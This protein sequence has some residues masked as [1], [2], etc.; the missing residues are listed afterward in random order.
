MARPGDKLDL[1]GAMLAAFPEIADGFVAF[2]GTGPDDVSGAHNTYGL[3]LSPWLVEMLRAGRLEL[4]GRVAALVETLLETNDD[5]AE[6]VVQLSLLE[7]LHDH[8]S[9]WVPLLQH[10][11]P[12][13]LALARVVEHWFGPAEE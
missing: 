9:I 10:L 2:I 8:P 6:E 1:N 13:G 11:G 7:A 3:L 5:Y 4:L 12:R